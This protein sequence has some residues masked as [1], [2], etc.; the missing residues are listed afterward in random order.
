MASSCRS[1]AWLAPALLVLA[2]CGG[3]PRAATPRAARALVLISIDG[4]RWDYLDRGITPNLTA[5]AARGVRARM[6]PTFPTK[7]F[8]QHYTIVTGV[9]PG[10][11]GIVGNNF[12]DASDGARFR[13]SDSTSARQ[14]RWWGAE[15]IWV[16]AER[17]GV[18]SASFFWPGSDVEIAGV[19]PSRYKNYDGSVPDSNRVDTVLAWLSLPL[20]QRPRVVSLYFSEVDSWGHERGPDSPELERALRAVDTMIG[21]LVV[22]LARAGLGD[23]VD[24]VV[25][26]DHGMAP[27]SERRVVLLD[28]YADTNLVRLIEAGALVL[29][30]TRGVTADSVLR[31]L[32]S[33]PHVTLYRR[34]LLPAAW[35]YPPT[36]RVPA[37][38]GVAEEGWTFTTRAA[39]ARRRNRFN[40]GDHGYDPALR[41]MHVLFVAAGPSFRPGVVAEPFT[42]VHVYELL[43]AMLGL[44][45]APNDGSLDSVRALLR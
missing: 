21:R 25:V 5:L 41:S 24:V 26:A 13:F 11:H 43:C 29:M 10:R 4:F 32:A 35:R 28:D 33:A 14:S 19:R 16:T 6:V 12:V 23:Q 1:A 2:A 31:L 34:D 3:P 42:N 9:H 27:T 17:Q 44:R 38:V 22:G 30:E 36:S 37:I 20:E 40:G 18:R 7:T 45:P 8:P 15:P 39:L